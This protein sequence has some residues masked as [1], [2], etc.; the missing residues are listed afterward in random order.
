MTANH[1]FQYPIVSIRNTLSREVRLSNFVIKSYLQQ[2]NKE[3]VKRC[4]DSSEEHRLLESRFVSGCFHLGWV[5]SLLFGL[6]VILDAGLTE[7]SQW[8]GSRQSGRAY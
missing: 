6:S 1:T 7:W 5:A 8:I 2:W 3:R 4:S